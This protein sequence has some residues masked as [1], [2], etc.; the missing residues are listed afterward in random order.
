MLLALRAR[1][2]DQRGAAAVEFA[3]L[4]V[5]LLLIVFGVISF[6]MMLSF[7]QTLSQAAT[8]GARAAA[9]E[10]DAAAREATAI[11]AV[12]D[13]L[14]TLDASHT[15]GD[16]VL[17]CEIDVGPCANDGSR[18]CVIV[19]LVYIYEGEGGDPMIPSPPLIGEL[20]PDTLTYAATARVS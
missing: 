13:A 6:G 14:A 12:E 1:R 17:T 4:L 2:N 8:E 20:L 7:R 3:L 15:C 19:E 11:T 18:D 10:T 5:P 16:G 9:V